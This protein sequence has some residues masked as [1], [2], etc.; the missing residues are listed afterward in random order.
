[1]KN[2]KCEKTDVKGPDIYIAP[3]TG[4]PEQQRFTIEVVY[5]PALAV[6]SAVQL[7]AARWPNKQALDPLDRPTYAPASH[8]Y[9][10]HP[11]MFSGNDSLFLEW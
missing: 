3:L 2:V 6:G 10:L 5:W 11:T 8:N 1:M 7:S 4:K 9:S